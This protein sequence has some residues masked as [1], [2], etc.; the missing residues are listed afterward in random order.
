[1]SKNK[2]IDLDQ[3]WQDFADIKGKIAESGCT[4]IRITTTARF[5]G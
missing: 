4:Q 1:M 3:L 2:Y 5:A